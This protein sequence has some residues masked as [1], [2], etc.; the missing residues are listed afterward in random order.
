MKKGFTLIELLVVVAIIGI[1]ATVIVGSLSSARE[2][3]KIAKI[4]TAMKSFLPQLLLTTGDTVTNGYIYGDCPA[5]TA[6][7]GTTILS[8]TKLM[9][10]LDSA[11]SVA[12]NNRARCY[13]NITSNN[14]WAIAVE[15]P[16]G[17]TVWCT[18]S[19]GAGK[20]LPPPVPRRYDH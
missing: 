7:A 19:S 18:D 8:D 17:N 13:F 11:R 2:K 9:A 4:Q 20:A 5:N 12:N 14:Q 16:D 10:I 1:L 6:A 15:Y 3:S